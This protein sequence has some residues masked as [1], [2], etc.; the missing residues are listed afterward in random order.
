LIANLCTPH[1]NPD[2]MKSGGWLFIQSLLAGLLAVFTPYVYTIHPFTTGFLT[3]N[4]KTENEKMEKSLI[5]AGVLVIFFTLFGIFVS[6]IIAA[7][8]LHKF[9]EH[10]I[11][12]L[13]F[14]RFFAVL[15]TSFLG[16]FSIKIP[17]SWI[18]SLADRAK[19]NDFR[20]IVYMAIT[21]PF[22]SFSST[23]P[24]IGLV[25]LLAWNATMA[26]PVIGLLGFGIGLALTFVF[27]AMLNIVAR[28]KSLLNSIKIILGFVSLMIALKLLSKADISLGLNLIDRELFIEI[29]IGLWTFMGIY[30]LG[31][32][33]FSGDTET[34]LNIYGQEYVSLLRLFIAIISFV[35][36][37]YLLPGIWGA[38]LRM[39]SGFLPT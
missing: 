17:A 25:L 33:K 38:P 8:G 2:L 37:V 4:V 24:I 20:G 14:F 10:W 36:A 6:V 16:A 19:T 35:F 26:G 27:P 22:A 15:G 11:F 7:T 5:Y 39:A 23:F 3:R 12:N 32:V 30:M 21:L 13:F 18:N 34:E 29:W 9:T 1:S 28:S 31:L